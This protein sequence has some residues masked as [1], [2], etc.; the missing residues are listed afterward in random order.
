V[1]RRMLLVYFVVAI[2]CGATACAAPRQT[3]GTRNSPCFR[4]LPTA[5]DA[6]RHNGHLLGVHR[7]SRT[8]LL[9]AFPRADL[10][11]DREFCVVGFS[12][13]YRTEQV[14]HPAGSPTGKFAVV[15]VTM[16]GT[17]PLQTFL[18]DKLPFQLRH[19]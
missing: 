13:D 4:S 17:T 19:R 14:D 6:V 9:D 3:L 5:Q 15:V 2:A 11:S 12:G 16:R 10:P 8:R 18:V 1:M 7:I